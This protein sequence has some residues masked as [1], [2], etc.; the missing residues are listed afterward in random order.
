[1]IW[2]C[3]LNFFLKPI[4]MGFVPMFSKNPKKLKFSSDSVLDFGAF[5]EKGEGIVWKT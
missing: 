4:K 5:E 2:N 3:T 1:M